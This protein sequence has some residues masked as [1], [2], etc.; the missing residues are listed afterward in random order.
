MRKRL[1]GR[2][3]CLMSDYDGT[4]TPIVTHP[5]EAH[6]SKKV[7]KILTELAR[8]SDVQVAII[9]GRAMKDITRCL[10]IPH[11][12]YAGNHGLEI[13][14]S[15]G[16]W[17]L[18]RAA[19]FVKTLASLQ[20]ALRKAIRPYPGVWIEDKKLTLSVHYRKLAQQHG[21]DLK[22]ALDRALTPFRRKI[23]VT[24]GKCV[25]EVRP[26][27]RWNKGYAATWLWRHLAPN[28]IP[29]YI[30]DN[31][32]DEDAFK[33]L[34]R[35][36]VGIRVGSGSQTHAPFWVRN[37]LDVISFFKELERMTRGARR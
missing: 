29:I 26:Q 11:A 13:R 5:E 35:H 12:A 28:S 37:T 19:S 10:R 18:P 15:R 1:K 33:S 8:N 32:T 9:T 24:D 27:V 21:P 7:I 3:I 6:P 36:G 34:S 23:K 17:V 14:K 2:K 16:L 20:M 4:L 30:G 25:R 31:K 22:A